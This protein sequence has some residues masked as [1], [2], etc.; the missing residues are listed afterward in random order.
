MYTVY[1]PKYKGENPDFNI[2]KV[3]KIYM[4]S[5]NYDCGILL[6]PGYMN[7]NVN[8]TDMYF[9]KMEKIFHKS[10]LSKN[11]NVS[12]GIFN[13]VNGTTL[14]NLGKKPGKITCREYHEYSIKSHGLNL[15][16]I[17][18]KKSSDHRKM[19]F[20]LEGPDMR[21]I[22]VED[23]E[24]RDE[25]RNEELSLANYSD[26]LTN[27][28][29][30]AIMIGSSNQSLQTYYGGSKGLSADKG[31]ADVFMFVDDSDVKN[32]FVNTDDKLLQDSIVI[33]KSIK[34]PGNSENERE[35]NEREEREKNE[36]DTDEKYLKS[37]LEDFLKNSLEQ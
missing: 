3:I 28:K 24:K 7:K 33:S 34:V 25:S 30:R 11:R 4:S 14:I 16:R 13:G 36:R 27:T 23:M 35:E 17:K 26:F 20:F 9:T 22:S 10:K 32:A 18:C 31:E 8:T 15:I 29:V 5:T 12:V 6:A 1:I 19:I 2:I 37:I 21:F